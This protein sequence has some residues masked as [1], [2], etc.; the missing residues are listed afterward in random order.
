MLNLGRCFVVGDAT[1]DAT[2]E[3]AC[4]IKKAIDVATQIFKLALAEQE[5]RNQDLLGI[6]NELQRRLTESEAAN[7]AMRG[8]LERVNTSL[9][10]EDNDTF[11]EFIKDRDKAL[12]T[13]AGRGWIPIEDVRPLLKLLYSYQDEETFHK[14]YLD[15]LAKHGDKLKTP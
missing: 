7:S 11:D 6:R 9:M 10:R 12:S 1:G 5:Q 3:M 2:M 14:S 4:E 13:D 15:F 8:L